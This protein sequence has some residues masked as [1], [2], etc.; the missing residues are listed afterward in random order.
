MY[1]CEY[2]QDSKKLDL[3]KLDLW[4]NLLLII[5]E[6]TDQTTRWVLPVLIA[7]KTV[8]SIYLL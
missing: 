7:R 3:N 4:A 6:T 2:F 1:F 5:C 8:S